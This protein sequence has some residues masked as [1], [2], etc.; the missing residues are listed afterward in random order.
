MERERIIVAVTGASGAELGFY[1][2]K[3]L[4]E[5]DIEIHLILSEG[6]KT[7][8]RAETK[9]H[10]N[11]FCA[12]ADYCYDETEL[13]ACIASGSFVTKGMIVVPCSMKTLS[14][15][16]NAYDENLCIRAADV[17]LKEKR[18]LV[19][20]PREMPLGNAHLRNLLTLAQDG[21]VILPPMLSFYAGADTVE[22]QIAQIIGK[23]LMQFDL[24]HNAFVSWKGAAHG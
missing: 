17:C 3:A 1:V 8:I 23:V 20:V 22:K 11:D 16:A 24:T 13:D 21:A 4:R 18:R 19:L 7:V 6:A 12:L 9:L 2:L 15:I 5:H 10:T 14:G